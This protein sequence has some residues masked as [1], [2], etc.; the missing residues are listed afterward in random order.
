L[1][2]RVI[3]PVLTW[4]KGPLRHHFCITS[5]N[6]KIYSINF[7]P[8]AVS[9]LFPWAY[10]ICKKS[11]ET[12]C[13]SFAKLKNE[14]TKIFYF[15]P[16]KLKLG[17]KNWF[18]SNKS[19]KTHAGDK[20]AIS[21]SLPKPQEHTLTSQREITYGHWAHPGQRSHISPT[22]GTTTHHFIGNNNI[23]AAQL[24][25]HQWN[26]GVA[27]QSYKTPHFHPRHRHLPSWHDPSENSVGSA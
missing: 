1:D 22:H 19:S 4:F 24:V 5:H 23:R 11:F 3:G 18:S 21:I 14:D 16:S 15:L 20:K 7:Q 27:G 9:K 6:K 26:A 8:V 25:D 17:H 12:S 2:H 10:H 13:L